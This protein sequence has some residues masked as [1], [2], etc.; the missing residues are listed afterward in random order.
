MT[1]ISAGDGQDATLSI[2]EGGPGHGVLRRLNLVQ[3]L[4]TAGLTRISLLLALVTWLPLAILSAIEGLAMRGTTIP[5][6]YDLSQH[7]RF[8]LAVPLLI[9]A[10]G[11]I[12]LRVRVTVRHFL[13]A[14]LVRA[15]D[16][17]RFVAMVA[18][19]VRLRDARVAEFVVIAIVAMS[20]WYSIA[21]GLGPGVGT[22]FV[23]QA[24][25]HF[26]LAGYWY[27][28][29][30]MPIFLFL[31]LRW[32][33]RVLVWAWLLKGIAKLDLQLTPTHPDGAG[34]LAFLGR[35]VA[36][37][38]TILFALSTVLSAA[39]ASRVLF[40]GASLYDYLPSYAA[41]M[42][43][44]L[45]IFAG[46][47]L[48]FAP[49]LF[50]VKERGLR[51]YGTLASRYTQLFQ[52]KWVGGGASSD[53]PLLGTGDI[54]SLADLANSYAVVDKMKVVPIDLGDL[55]VLAV[56]A[57]IPAIPLAATVMPVGEIVKEL[58]KLLA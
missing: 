18:S 9:L 58:F 19:A 7:V 51:E 57:V 20:C 45:V 42:V 46:P 31:L 48:L 12:G 34:G 28:F 33:F 39:V 5:F 14:G 2:V 55:I 47:L 52:R 22:W 8:L 36:L 53:E 54:Q 6:L 37:F 4:S 38:G 27:A 40:G 23:P 50:L 17:E 21:W 10:E 1:T 30:C 32:V 3:P 24:R 11:P 41:L 29:V 43:L 49:K 26:S 13:I 56:P 16:H 44:A 25:G 35:A 15:E